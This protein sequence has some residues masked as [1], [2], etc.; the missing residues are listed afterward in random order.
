MMQEKI[1]LATLTDAQ[2]IRDME[3]ACFQ[4]DI[5]SLKQIRYFI[6][7]PT[8]SFLVLQSE[9]QIA[10]TALLLF[11]KNAA[12][13]R[14]YSFAIHPAFRKRGYAEKLHAACLSEILHK[15]LEKL[16]LE[17]RP[18]NVAALAFY[19]KQQYEKFGEFANFYEDGMRAIRLKKNL[20]QVKGKGSKHDASN[21]L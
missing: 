17:V 12:F 20:A 3:E 19:E 9:A 5:L 7:S 4:Q 14:L 21:K 2:A 18:D 6:N 11:R 15:G 8:A 13:A 10:G 1:R 16:V